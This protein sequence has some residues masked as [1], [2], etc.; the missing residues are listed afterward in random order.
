MH[1]AL[2]APRPLG[3]KVSKRPSTSKRPKPLARKAGV[4]K[5]GKEL[6]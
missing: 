6:I 5:N 3:H 4:S 2:R 1:H